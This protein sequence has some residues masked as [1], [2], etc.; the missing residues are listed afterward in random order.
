MARYWGA[1]G[2]SRLPP[3]DRISVIHL[4]RRAQRYKQWTHAED[5]TSVTSDGH[6]HDL[7]GYLTPIRVCTLRYVG[8]TSGFD[9]H[10]AF[11]TV[12]DVHGR[13]DHAMSAA[14]FAELVEQFQPLTTRLR[15]SPV[16]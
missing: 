15:Y 16:F 10:G 14:C 12:W 7:D 4:P 1:G 3:P 6:T 11:G 13:W 5:C 2:A 9:F 8:K